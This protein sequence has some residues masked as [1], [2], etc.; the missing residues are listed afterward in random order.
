[1][2]NALR[3]DNSLIDALGPLLPLVDRFNVALQLSL[4][5]H[6]CTT[7]HSHGFNDGRAGRSGR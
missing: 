5:S 4:C 3:N 7:Q 1:M 2:Q 6:S